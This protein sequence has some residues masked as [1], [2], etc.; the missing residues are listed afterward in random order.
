VFI[1][2]SGHDLSGLGMV[3][4]R[5]GAKAVKGVNIYPVQ[6]YSD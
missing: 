2:R 4:V 6:T 5:F 3:N 1:F